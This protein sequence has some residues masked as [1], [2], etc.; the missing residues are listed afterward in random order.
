M[1]QLILPNGEII[2]SGVQGEPAILSV[3]WRQNRNSGGEISPGT[4]CCAELEMELF[5]LKKP[6]I[7]PETRL[8]YQEDGIIRGIFYCQGI[9]RKSRNRW[10][11]TALDGMCRFYREINDF[12]ETRTDD[13]AL[14]LLQGLCAHC[15]VSTELSGFPGCNTPLPKLAGYSAKQI[16]RFLAQLAG[17]YFYMDGEEKLCAGWFTQ[18]EQLTDYQHLTVAEYTTEPIRRVLIRQSKNDVGIA[19]PEGETPLN[20]LIIQ[21]NPIF[22]NSTMSEFSVSVHA[23]RLLEQLWSFTHTPFT[24]RLLPGQEVSPGGFVEFT[25]PD[26]VKRIGA[27]MQWEKKNGVL[28]VRG[29]GSHSLGSVEAFRE[30]TRENMEGQVLELS[31]TTQGLSVSH[32][33]LLGDVGALQL[34]VEGISTQVTQGLSQ[35]ATALSQTAQGLHLQV[36]QLESRLNDKTDQ[37]EFTQVTE[38]FQF[39][40]DGLTIQNSATGMGIRV[41]QEQV[42]FLGGD[43]AIYPD[44]METTK[45]AVEKRLDIGN[46]SYLPRTNGNL[47]FRYTGQVTVES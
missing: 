5:S 39:D 31:R 12:W 28:T 3:C 45:L 1:E 29:T 33:N 41:S 23:Q 14:T 8:V 11:L 19:Y 6:D 15:G 9:T 4:V 32:T 18:K 43:T 36:S 34:S 37:T 40:A 20:T 35:Q 42:A 21:G 38:H 2:A 10:V 25:D 44:A 7:P 22:Q 47:S 24:C 27:V 13:T 17:R 30:L 26:G 16:L 46:F